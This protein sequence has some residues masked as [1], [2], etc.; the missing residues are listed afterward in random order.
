MKTLTLL[1]AFLCIA[2]PIARAE[3]REGKEGG[4]GDPLANE[5]LLIGRLFERVQKNEP[6]P[7]VDVNAD[8]VQA[9]LNDIEASLEGKN[10]LIVFPDGHVVECFG[11]PKLGC[12][13]DGRIEIA[14]IGW[15]NSTIAEKVAVSAMELLLSMGIEDRYGKAQIIANALARDLTKDK[16]GFL[17]ELER[18]PVD[19]TIR[20]CDFETMKPYFEFGVKA[21]VAKKM[22]EKGIEIRHDS[23]TFEYL[24]KE[25][26][27]PGNT[28]DPETTEEAV[29]ISFRTKNGSLVTLATPEINSKLEFALREGRFRFMT[30][31]PKIKLTRDAEGF[32]TRR[33]CQTIAS[34]IQTIRGRHVLYVNTSIDNYVIDDAEQEREIPVIVSVDLL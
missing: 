29:A 14:R 6:I 11:A 22:Q 5:F 18:G 24:G 19:Q 4:G 32:I 12:V 20:S 28:F 3:L 23:F 21:M 25:T 33:E 7:G 2:S 13:K 15:I 31:N 8:A 17:K 1:F 26:F 16:D 34:S 30:P 9:K 10:P 27:R